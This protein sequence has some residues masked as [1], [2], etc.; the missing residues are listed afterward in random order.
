MLHEENEKS[1][2]KLETRL[3][4]KLRRDVAVSLEATGDRIASSFCNTYRVFEASSEEF[5][6][7]SSSSSQRQQI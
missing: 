7:T 5:I 4:N 1:K 3:R 6:A 2:A